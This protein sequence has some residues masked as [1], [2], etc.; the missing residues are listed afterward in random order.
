LSNI[1]LSDTSTTA[2]SK[3]NRINV[4]KSSPTFNLIESVD[5]SHYKHKGAVHHGQHSA[6]RDEDASGW[7]EG[8]TSLKDNDQAMKLLDQVAEVAASMKVTS[9]SISHAWL[10]NYQY[11]LPKHGT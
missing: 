5:M 3:T 8:I 11:F 1:D 7:V 4:K 9:L 2:P 10:K 6:K